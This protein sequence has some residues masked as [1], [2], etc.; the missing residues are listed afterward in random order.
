MLSAQCDLSLKNTHAHTLNHKHNSRK[1][2]VPGKY[3]SL[4]TYI[5]GTH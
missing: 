2:G 3:F 1:E 4:E 5:V